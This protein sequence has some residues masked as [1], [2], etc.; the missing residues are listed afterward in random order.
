MKYYMIDIESMG[1]DFKND[2]IIQIGILECVKNGNL[3]TPGR[4]YQRNLFTDQTPKN[5]WIANTHKNLLPIC[6]KLD[7]A[8]PVEIRADIL[9]FFQQCGEM[10]AVNVMGLNATNFDIPYMVTKGYLVAPQDG[11]P[12]DYSYRIYELRGAYALAKDILNLSDD[13]ELFELTSSMP[14]SFMLPSG[15]KHEALYDCYKQ[16]QTLNGILSVASGVSSI[17]RGVVHAKG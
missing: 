10:G 5:E 4:S 6:Q 2:D 8:S 3:Y 9:A 14:S 1:T 7:Y 17:K 13:K 15:Q 11:R 12:G 16:L